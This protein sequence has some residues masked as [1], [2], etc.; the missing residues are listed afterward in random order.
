MVCRNDQLIFV[1]NLL[2]KKHLLFEI[3]YFLDAKALILF[4]VKN[5]FIV[6][7]IPQYISAIYSDSC[8]S[9]IFFDKI[10]KPNFNK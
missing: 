2:I 3:L 10:V 7:T 6:E 8:N 9:N 1:N 4:V 5:S